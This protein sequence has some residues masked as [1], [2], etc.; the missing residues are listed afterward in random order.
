MVVM[1]AILFTIP[2]SQ[3]NL[4]ANNRFVVHTYVGIFIWMKTLEIS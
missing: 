4:F 2:N 3:N 1:V